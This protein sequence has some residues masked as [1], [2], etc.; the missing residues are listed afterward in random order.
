VSVIRAWDDNSLSVKSVTDE[1]LQ[2]LFVPHPLPADVVLSQCSFHP[3]FPDR[4]SQIQR[5]M[6]GGISTW[7]QSLG[8]QQSAILA[9]LSKQAVRDHKNVRLGSEG[10]VGASAPSARS[11]VQAN[12]PGYLQGT[13]G[14]AQAQGSYDQFG[15]GL[16]GR[17]SGIES[18]GPG[19]TIG[20]GTGPEAVPPAVPMF[21]RPGG[22]QAGNFYGDTPPFSSQSYMSYPGRP[23]SDVP[24]LPQAHPSRRPHSPGSYQGHTYGFTPPTQHGFPLAPEQSSYLPPGPSFTEPGL[25]YPYT[26]GSSS[27][28]P[29]QGTSYP[30]QS[31]PGQQGTGIQRIPS[32]D[33][34]NPVYSP[35]PLP[36]P[37][38]PGTAPGFSSQGGRRFPDPQ[39]DSAYGSGSN[40][41]YGHGTYQPE[42]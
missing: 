14:I 37:T 40:S 25:P 38:F 22:V 6:L 23:S 7:L 11:Q 31:Y 19:T 36:P 3:D 5:E 26:G 39:Y 32:P 10:S 4:S 29:Y 21:T 18:Y 20:P 13:P 1:I 41:G 24:A 15:G 28:S 16:G 33:N 42:Y 8:H 30:G 35:P 2:C 12:T 27:G 17:R 34:T 9:R